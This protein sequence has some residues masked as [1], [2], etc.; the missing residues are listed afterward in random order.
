MGVNNILEIV[1]CIKEEIDE[2]RR[3]Q[4]L[5]DQEY[6]Q[7]LAYVETLSIIQSACVGYDLAEIDLDFDVDERYLK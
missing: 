2:L 3:K 1:S 7:L 5:S 6:G 4:S